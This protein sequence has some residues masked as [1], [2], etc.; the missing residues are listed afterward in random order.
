MLLVG[1]EANSAL[2]QAYTINLNGPWISGSIEV[3]FFS[4]P[5]WAANEL[6]NA[7][8]TWNNAQK[9]FAHDYFP[10]SKAYELRESNVS[11]ITVQFFTNPN[12]LT[13][14]LRGYL[15][16]VVIR[17]QGDLIVRVEMQ[18]A[19]RAVDGSELSTTNLF[20]LGLHCFGNAL[21]LYSLGSF[22][23][24]VMFGPISSVDALNRM[25]NSP[26]TLDLYGLHLLANGPNGSTPPSAATLPASIP[27]GPAPTVSIGSTTVS[28]TVSEAGSSSLATTAQS[29]TLTPPATELISTSSQTVAG[30]VLS[31]GLLVV[32]VLIAFVVLAM[33]GYRKRASRRKES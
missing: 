29:S 33:V 20:K 14:P 9:W 11:S 10:N 27:Y 2:A 19:L 15:C 5:E 23:S 1:L 30:T 12:D 32:A 6:R 28:V 3:S 24:D 17:H 22:P 8:S 4:A 26:S 21:G 18:A 13:G 25:D 7:M 16:G 31:S